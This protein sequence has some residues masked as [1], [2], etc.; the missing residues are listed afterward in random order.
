MNKNRTLILGILMAV[1]TSVILLGCSP[2]PQEPQVSPTATATSTPVFTATPLPTS[3]PTPTIPPTPL[4]DP[5]ELGDRLA[6]SVAQIETP[7]GSGAGFLVEG[8]YLVTS[9]NVVWPFGTV[10][11]TFADG[12]KFENV[13]VVQWDLVADLAVIG[14]VATDAQP[15]AFYDG[16]DLRPGDA[17]LL[18][19]NRD[20]LGKMPKLEIAEK[21]ILDAWEWQKTGLTYFRI[22]ALSSELPSGGL[23]FSE[24]GQLVGFSNNSVASGLFGYMLSVSD[25]AFTLEKI[26]SGEDADGVMRNLKDGR[27]K[28]GLIHKAKIPYA[29]SMPTY[30]IWE[31]PGTKVELSIVFKEKKG[32]TF[33]ILNVRGIVENLDLKKLSFDHKTDFITHLDAPYF[34]EAFS[35]PYSIPNQGVIG[36]DHRLI[37]YDDPDDNQ[38]LAVDNEMFGIS[39]YPGDRDIYF[40]SLKGGET[41]R[42][43]IES[44]MFKPAIAISRAEPQE[45]GKTLARSVTETPVGATVDFTAPDDGQ[46]ILYVSGQHLSDIGAYYLSIQSP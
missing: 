17:V 35:Y 28:G 45:S 29:F 40:I 41:I 5:R 26:T 12:V 33:Q 1:V 4:P 20:P 3:L 2:Q 10:T 38:H 18:L 7:R 36:S 11:A 31:N 43:H 30:V 39:D 32:F 6:E 23:L 24:T 34:L 44:A 25:I 9:A 14:P 15:V 8:N 13:P 42:G 16:P 19:S 37:P 27:K 46:Y 21:D 22:K